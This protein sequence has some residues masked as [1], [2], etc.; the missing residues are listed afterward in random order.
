MCHLKITLSSISFQV[1]NPPVVEKQVIFILPCKWGYIGK[2][3][4]RYRV[5]FPVCLL[6]R[7]RIYQ[8]PLLFRSHI[9]VINDLWPLLSLKF[10]LGKPQNWVKPWEGAFSSFLG[11]YIGMNLEIIIAANNQI[12]ILATDASCK[13]ENVLIMKFLKSWPLL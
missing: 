11:R 9:Q 13:R 10:E 1:K 4:C 2:N 12:T 6:K 3:T 8:I 7:K 5:V